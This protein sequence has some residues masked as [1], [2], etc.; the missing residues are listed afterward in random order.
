MNDCRR[1]SRFQPVEIGT[2]GFSVR[3]EPVEAFN[4]VEPNPVG[5]VPNLD[6]LDQ[7]H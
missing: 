2:R 3:L 1:G 4:A 6:V 7:P 5:F